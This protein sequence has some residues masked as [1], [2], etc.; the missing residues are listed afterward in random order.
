[1][2]PSIVLRSVL[3]D[4][5]FYTVTGISCVILLPTLLLPR[6]VFLAVV[7]YF[8]HTTAFLEKHILGLTFEIRGV[9]NLPDHGPWLIAAK[10]Q[11]AYET[12]KLHILFDDPA[13]VLKKQLLRIPLW[14]WY[15]AKSDV[16]AID[17]I[18]PKAAIESIQ[19]GAKRMAAQRRP[20]IIFPQ[21]TRV[22]VDTTTEQRPYK[23]G[24][25][26]IQEATGLPIIPLAL[27]TGV[28]WPRNSFLKKPGRVV[29]EF[30]PPI[31]PGGKDSESLKLLQERLEEKSKSL[32]Q[33]AI[34]TTV[35]PA[36]K[37]LPAAFI[38]IFATLWSLN[39]YIAARI[40][41]HAVQDFIAES[42]QNPDLAGSVF[43]NPVISGFPFK[44]TLTFGPQKIQ[45]H[46]TIFDIHSIVAQS[47][48]F[49][50]FPITVKTGAVLINTPGWAKPVVYDEFTTKIKVR[51]ETLKIK[52]ATLKS[53]I[54]E[55][56]TSGEVTLAK[57]YPSIN[58]MINLKN[59]EHLLAELKESAA[60]D[61]KGAD[62]A[63][64][65]L[66]SMKDE[67]GV[68]LKIS[69]Q[70][71]NVYLGPIRVHQFPDAE[72]SAALLEDGSDSEIA[73][74]RQK[75]PTESAV[76]PAPDQ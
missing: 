54:F 53:G 4:I 24:I 28:F 64:V 66:G 69:S 40:T 30:L 13:I 46:D 20:I 67:N 42:S 21:G 12:T 18:S 1:M 8:V 38:G 62:M 32:A 26:R 39:W 48:P 65:T 63:A 10:H 55:G 49:M 17:R 70:G 33:E 23:I 16:I 19:A 34:N 59:H 9:E 5:L 45:N 68:S 58:L 11:S 6:R 25:I 60:V 61:Q 15:L 57:P 37:K 71:R 41:D 31:L 50:N 29:F 44:L 76:T 52:Y 72:Q 35:K 3:F 51:G 7:K 75:P 47:W 74:R 27:N 56:S 43:T 36:S 14:G 73:T 22:F 2:S